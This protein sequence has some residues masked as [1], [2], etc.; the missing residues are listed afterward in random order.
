[1]TIRSA[2]DVFRDG[3]PTPPLDLEQ[4]PLSRI[5]RRAIR[6]RVAIIGSAA[7]SILLVIAVLLSPLD[8]PLKDQPADPRPTTSRPSVDEMF[9]T[10]RLLTL[11]GWQESGLDSAWHTKL[12]AID[13]L[14]QP[15]PGTGPMYRPEAI[16]ASDAF[17]NGH[18]RLATTL[19]DTPQPKHAITFPDGKK[20]SVDVLAAKWTF[21]TMDH[22]DGDPACAGQPGCVLT[23]TG[24]R[25]GKTTMRTS[26]G[27]I[28]VPAWYFTVKEL[29]VPVVTV[30][31]DPSAI[32][33]F[34]PSS[35]AKSVSDR[36][37]DGYLFSVNWMST[38]AAPAEQGRTLTVSYGKSA[39][40][41]ERRGLVYETNTMIFVSGFAAP[42]RVDGHV[43]DPCVAPL[44]GDT[45]KIQLQK[46]IGSRII[47][48]VF[49]GTPLIFDGNRGW[50][51]NEPGPNT[52]RIDGH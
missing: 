8:L 33:M 42:Y 51:P 50:R 13:G 17:H 35:W 1:M 41:R 30:A 44:P 39:C 52:D 40:D 3:V 36:P 27:T 43:P 38:P 46:P 19:P 25:L 32:T 6:R 23:V 48:D 22:G 10:Q 28:E 45:A 29:F 34:N 14:S 21:V 24:V 2:E 31:I 47:F 18:Y 9:G 20:M 11:E 49:T 4:P 15:G 37:E 7:A 12:V 5:R 16:W 26:R